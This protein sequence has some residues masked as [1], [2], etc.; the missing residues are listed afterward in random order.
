MKQISLFALAI[1]LSLGVIAKDSGDDQTIFKVQTDQSKVVWTGKKVTGQHA[2]T[3]AI[4]GGEVKLSSNELV[5]AEIIMDM[6]S[7]SNTDLKD[8]NWN[9]KLVGH[10]KSE[11]FFSVEKYPQ[12]SFVTTKIN[13]NENAG[14]KGYTVTG[15]LTIKGI[16]NE[17]E[18]PVNVSIE[19]NTLKANGKATIDRTKWDIKYGSGSFFS[20]LGDKAIYDDFEIEFD[21]VANSEAAN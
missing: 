16:T 4:D 8:P 5:G 17:V 19:G 10:L 1:S 15:N 12:A 9:E 21:L 7:I 13:K 2:G 3:V 11:D 18:F 20:D 6:N 14:K